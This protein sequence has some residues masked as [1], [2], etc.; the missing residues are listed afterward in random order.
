MTTPIESSAGELGQG[1]GFVVALDGFTGPLDLLL[2]LVR[3]EQIDI[4]D[5]PVARIADQ[6]LRII[7]SLG[8]NQA[9]DYLEMAGRLIRLKAQLLLPR[10]SDDEEWIDPRAELVRRL[11][12]YQ[13]IKEIALQFSRLAERRALRCA[14]G[15]LPPPSAAPPPLPLTIDILDLL[16]AVE[17]VVTNI[18][19]PV[20][21]SV[22][23]RPLDVESAVLRIEA[24][25]ADR[26]WFDWREALGPQ[27]TIVVLLSTLLAILELA[28]R[29]VCR[30]RQ[31]LPFAPLVIARELAESAVTTA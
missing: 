20:L 10:R 25:L 4:S 24:L 31:D 12:E 15:Y 1:A 6:F 16:L 17:R 21:H 11:L 18:P 26:D 3:E 22:V 27:P 5:I 23:T 14:R 13:Q 9:A 2:H 29:G 8:L 30:V 28:R 7:H 19:S